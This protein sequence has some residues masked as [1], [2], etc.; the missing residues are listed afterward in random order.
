MQTLFQGR[1]SGRRRRRTPPELKR[2]G[3]DIEIATPLYGI[4]KQEYIGSKENEY[5]IRFGGKSER[6]EVYRGDLSGIPVHFVKNP[7]YFEGNYKEPYIN[8]PHIPFYDDILRFSF[9]SEACL[10]LIEQIKPDIVH[11]ND[12][13]LGYLFG[14]MAMTGMPQKRILTY[15]NIGYQGNIG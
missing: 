12:W 5:D 14:R 11:I 9:F 1:G 10:Q 13:P 4:V 7:S 15:H 8:S 3:V 6:I 2:Q